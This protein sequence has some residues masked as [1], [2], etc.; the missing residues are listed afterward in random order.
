MKTATVSDTK[1]SFDA[2][3]N[4]MHPAERSFN[5]VRQPEAAQPVDAT[6]AFRSGD[7]Q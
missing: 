7:S 6:Q 2:L 3:Q 4:V 5:P 1:V